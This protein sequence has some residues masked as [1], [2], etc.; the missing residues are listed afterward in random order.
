MSRDQMRYAFVAA[1]ILIG[2]AI[3]YGLALIGEP[4]SRWVWGWAL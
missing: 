1:V 4:Q 2:L 3:S